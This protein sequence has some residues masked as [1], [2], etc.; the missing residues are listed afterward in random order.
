MV[1][2]NEMKEETAL[3][4]RFADAYLKLYPYTEP[5]AVEWNEE[6]GRFVV[7]AV[8]EAWLKQ[9]ENLGWCSN[10]GCGND[11]I[12][13]AHLA[14]CKS[15]RPAVTAQA[16]QGALPTP[17]NEKRKLVERLC[18]YVFR[19]FQ[20]DTGEQ[21]EEYRHQKK[22]LKAEIESVMRS[23]SNAKD[24]ELTCANV[25]IDAQARQIYSLKNELEN[26]AGELN[27]KLAALAAA[28]QALRDAERDAAIGFQV[29]RAC[30]ELPFGFDLHIELEKD[31][32]TVRL[33]H[34][35]TD[36]FEREFEAD[37][38]AGQ[39]SAAIDAALAQREQQGEKG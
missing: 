17:A 16:P 11:I 27:D 33:Y 4:K 25:T 1:S 15:A 28:Q 31:A 18:D 26:L 35:D 39:I 34:P 12:G 13:Y 20:H 7:A 37:T 24:Y 19:V 29:L 21:N 32:G 14:G 30:E 2:D 10:C 22:H 6:R 38:F 9:K 8:Q 3:R 23:Y 36:A 5:E